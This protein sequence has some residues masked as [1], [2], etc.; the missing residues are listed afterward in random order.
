MRAVKGSDRSYY[1]TAGISELRLSIPTLKS[2]ENA[3]GGIKVTWSKVTGATSYYVYRK[4]S[5][6]SW[7]RIATATSTSYTDSSSL[8]SGTTYIYT[9]RAVKG[10]DRSYYKTA[11]ISEL[12]LSIP[13]LKT[14]TKTSSGI[15]VTWGKVT[16]A[17]G[18]YV[19]RKPSGG[20]WT[21]IATTA[22]TSY[23]DTSTTSTSYIYTV[24]A[25]KGSDRSYHS[26]VGISAKSDAKSSMT[27]KAQSY[28]SNTKYLILVNRSTHKV[29]VYTG[30][31][32]NWTL[33]Y[34]WSCVTGTSSTPTITGS[35][36]TT[37]FY[38]TRLTTDSRARWATQIY[39]GYFFHSILVSDSELGGSLSHGCI[40]LSVSNAKW[41]YNN[42][43]KGTR[44]VIY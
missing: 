40:R 14:A 1:K 8:K 23:T 38:R 39:G 3:S 28:S 30:S 5:G 22:S 6:G 24:R 34:Y 36:L 4:T 31:K 7:T 18:Y 37:G 17:A 32:G 21:R 19:Y 11:G 20:T 42:I 43:K 35:Y 13:T 27:N 10:S 33:K 15:K 2:A 16:G 25:Y 9:V 26:T 29:G 12:R 41:I 44:V